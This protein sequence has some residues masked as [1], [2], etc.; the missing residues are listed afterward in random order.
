MDVPSNVAH[1]AAL[2]ENIFM[3]VVCIE[4]RIP[5]FIVGKPGSSKSLAKSIVSNSMQGRYSSN[6]LLNRFKQVQLFPYQC[7]QFSTTDSLIEVFKEAQKFQK[8]QDVTKFASVV[9]LEEIGLAEDAPGLPLKVLHPYLEDGTAGVD[10]EEMDIKPEERV[11]FIGISNWALD[12]AKM[13]RGIMV[14]R[15][16]PEPQELIKSAH[17]IANIVKDDALRSELT[18]SFDALAKMYQSICFKQEQ[19]GTKGKEDEGREFYGLRDFYTMIKMFCWKCIDSGAPP[20]PE[21]YRRIILRNFSGHSRI[22]P[23][24]ELTN[25]A[26]LISL[27]VSESEALD[28]IKESLEPLKITEEDDLP[29]QENRYLLFIT[30]NQSALRILQTELLKNETPFIFYGSSFPKDTEY[31]QVCVNIN[32]IKVCM[33]KGIP[34]VLL[35]YEQIYESLYDVLNQCYT[36]L[37][38]GRYVDLGLRS[39]RI[40]CRVHPNFRLIIIA[41]RDRIF[42][43]FPTALINRLEKHFVVSETI[44]TGRQKALA[45]K[46]RNWVENF[47]DVEHDGKKLVMNIEHLFIICSFSVSDSFVGYQE[48]TPSSI[49]LHVC[50]NQNEIEQNELH[51]NFNYCDIM[52][53]FL[54]SSRYWKKVLVW[55]SKLLQ[56]MH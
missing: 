22:N 32:K 30:E 47:S 28:I 27:S 38:T 51:V 54:L 36:E 31:T 46:F 39:Y 16:S 6:E 45:A 23:L 8:S 11:A 12:P 35:N 56:L 7:N 41:E 33:E 25:P 49:I 24:D 37:P 2:R 13:N 14:T 3:M 9:V 18:K 15:C 48:D 17:G 44:L 52:K 40:K 19:G 1:N 21:D 5:L 53:L 34:V 43:Q 26:S 4:N 42:K 50:Q 10:P 29:K 55:F 20:T